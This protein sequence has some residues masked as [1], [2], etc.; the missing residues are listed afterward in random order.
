MHTFLVTHSCLTLC[1]PMDCSPPG[2]P[3]HWIFQARILEWVPFSS[4]RYLPHPGIEPMSPALQVVFC[5]G[6]RFFTYRAT[7]T[8]LYFCAR[9]KSKHTIFAVLFWHN[10]F[11]LCV[12][13]LQNE[14][15]CRALLKMERPVSIASC[16]LTLG[17]RQSGFKSCLN[18]HDNFLPCLIQHHVLRPLLLSLVCL[19]LIHDLLEH[20]PFPTKHTSLLKEHI[21]E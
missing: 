15:F 14:K 1:N 13:G 3:V 18:S 10:F 7:G 8:V 2:S 19:R 12:R 9:M 16:L 21:L 20:R 4:P 11:V 5:I 17:L 6:D